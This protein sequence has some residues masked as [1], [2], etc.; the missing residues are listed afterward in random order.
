MTAG[1]SFVYKRNS[2]EPSTEPCGTPRFI[3]SQF[4]TAVLCFV[5]LS[6]RTHWYL[7]SILFFTYNV[8]VQVVH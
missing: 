2:V 5:L 7:E 1:K 6:I 3:I 4:E 8:F